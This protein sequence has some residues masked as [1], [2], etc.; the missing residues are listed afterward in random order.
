[1]TH[2]KILEWQMTGAGEQRRDI[3]V[4]LTVPLLNEE[5]HRWQIGWTR[6]TDARTQYDHIDKRIYI[7][8]Q[9]DTYTH[10][11]TDTHVLRTGHVFICNDSRK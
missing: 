10:I 11:R 4:V 9:T 7:Y 8:R 6:A 3:A 5:V 2:R 1:M